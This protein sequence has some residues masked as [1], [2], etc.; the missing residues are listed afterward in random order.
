[1]PMDL[2]QRSVIVHRGQ[3]EQTMIENKA[4]NVLHSHVSYIKTKQEH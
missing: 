3:F 1:M 2:K 4:D